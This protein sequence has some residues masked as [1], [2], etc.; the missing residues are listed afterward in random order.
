MSL[1]RSVSNIYFFRLLSLVVGFGS[2]LVVIP[3][4]TSD[5]E[6]YAIYAV[7]SS[8]SLFL[9]YGDLGFLS[10]CQ[11]FCTEAVARD[12]I[13]EEAKYI[14]FTIKVL[15]SVFAIF[16]L[17]MLFFAANPSVIFSDLS[18][19]NYKFASNMFVVVAVFM[20]IQIILQRIIFI[21][22]ASRL[23]DYLFT[24][25]D[26]LFNVAKIVLAPMFLIGENFLL[27]EYFAFTILIS[28]CSCFIGILIIVKQINFPI[29][30]IIKNFRFDKEVFHKMKGLAGSMMLSTLCFVLY[31]EM[32]LIVAVTFFAIEEVA[33]YALAFTLI[34]FLRALWVLV[35]APLLVIMNSKYGLGDLKGVVNFASKICIFMIPIFILGP[36]LLLK[37]SDQIV[38]YW[39]GNDYQP[40]A[41]I[42]NILLA[43]LVLLG[44]SNVLSH[45]LVT[46]ERNRSIVLIALFPLAVYF[47][48]FIL[49]MYFIPSNNIL[50]LAY[51]KSGSLLALSILSVFLLFKERVIDSQILGQLSF[52]CVIGLCGII[53]MPSFLKL[54]FLDN[55]SNMLILIANLSYL[56]LVEFIVLFL[57]LCIFSSSRNLLVEVWNNFRGKYTLR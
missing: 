8:L 44:F 43:G 6:M 40:S 46:F 4:I 20:P 39:V 1:A 34:N 31:Y 28:F 16:S 10:A 18:Y 32:D 15:L 29:K 55:Q 22:L 13:S 7:I 33:L 26:T 17:V 37:H 19:V 54:G 45:Y 49:L 50:N 52:F 48:L 35:F 5:A 12:S 3:Y 21:V 30:Q 14:G 38:F 42:I 9:S 41:E 53:F 27:L 11:K 36:L 24:R 57:S 23:K 2:M 47:A 25:I 56:L 51:A